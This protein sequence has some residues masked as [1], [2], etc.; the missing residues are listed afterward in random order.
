M[1]RN[2]SNAKLTYFACHLLS[3]FQIAAKKSE[4]R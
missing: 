2:N 4:L 3:I 1:V